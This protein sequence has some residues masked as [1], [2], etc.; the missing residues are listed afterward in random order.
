[1][2]PPLELSLQNLHPHSTYALIV[3]VISCDHFRYRYQNFEW[4][5]T[6]VEIYEDNVVANEKNNFEFDRLKSCDE[7]SKKYEF[8]DKR[9]YIHPDSPLL[10][11]EWMKRSEK[12]VLINK[13]K[14]SNCTSKG[15]DKVFSSCYKY[16]IKSIYYEFDAQKL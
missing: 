2:F 9:A 1:M 12:G 15:N 11:R 7:K 13:I 14:F 16:Q 6:N 5:A 4:R 8:T 10:G 3:E